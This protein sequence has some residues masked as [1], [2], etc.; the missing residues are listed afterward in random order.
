MTD[1]IT[2]EKFIDALEVVGHDSE[3]INLRIPVKIWDEY[4][5]NRPEKYIDDAEQVIRD[6]RFC[7][8]EYA[9]QE[10]ETIQRR[11]HEIAWQFVNATREDTQ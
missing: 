9:E 4:M 6:I 3:V 7:I 2:V 10:P 8:D 5:G 1:A 11:L